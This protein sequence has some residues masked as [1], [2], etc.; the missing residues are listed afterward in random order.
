MRLKMDGEWGRGNLNQSSSSGLFD[1]ALSHHFLNLV[2]WQLLI[3]SSS[4]PPLIYQVLMVFSTAV[5]GIVDHSA[6]VCSKLRV[7]DHY[8]HRKKMQCSEKEGSYK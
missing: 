7:K 3:K 6:R 1:P 2:S 4:P 5:T 8:C